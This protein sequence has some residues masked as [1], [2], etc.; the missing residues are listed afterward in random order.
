M[1]KLYGG[2][3]LF[4]SMALLAIAVPAGAQTTAQTTSRAAVPAPRYEASKEVTLQG[5]VLDVVTKAPA[6]KLI[7]AH[8]IVATSSGDVD[9]HLGVY[10]LKGTN[11]LT[12]TPGERVQ[13]VG[14]MTTAGANQVFLVRTIQAGSQTHQIRNVHGFLLRPAKA[15]KGGQA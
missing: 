8:V 14:V 2:V 11:A 15:S 9:A 12:L 4:A 5:N 6:G 3:I 13:L 7:G 1:R 10:A